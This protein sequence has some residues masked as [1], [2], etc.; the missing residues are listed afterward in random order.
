MGDQFGVA[1]FQ[2][3]GASAGEF[4]QRL[5]KLAAFDG[6]R[7]ERIL[8][9]RNAHREIPQGILP[10]LAVQR[11]HHQRLLFGRTD[12]HAV[13]ATGAVVDGDRQSELQVFGA[14]RRF[15]SEACRGGR[16]FL[17]GRQNRTDAGMRTDKRTLVALDTV[18]HLPLRHIDRDTAFFVGGGSERERAVLLSDQRAHRQ[19]VT[20]LTVHRHQDLVDEGR[21]LFLQLAAAGAGKLGLVGLAVFRLGPACRHSHLDRRLHALRDR[22]IIHFDD[23]AA[24]MAIGVDDCVAQVFFGFFQRDDLRQFEKRDLHQNVEPAAKSD[25]LGELNGIDGIELD[26]VGRDV[27]FHAAGQFFVQFR[28]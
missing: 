19:F 10:Q 27:A 15:G 25:V 2:T 23:F 20:F 12:F 9:R 24:F 11:F 14:D 7:I 18:L 16:H 6:Q 5:F 26:V 28:L 13:A 3:T 22:R 1:G 21:N 17:A 4:Q 8:L